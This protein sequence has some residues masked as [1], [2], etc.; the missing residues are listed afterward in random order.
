MENVMATGMNF[1]LFSKPCFLKGFLPFQALLLKVQ[2]FFVTNDAEFRILI[3]VLFGY[4]LLI[5]FIEFMEL[6]SELDF[7][8]L[9]GQVL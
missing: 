3:L 2:K 6:S 8:S 5:N 7:Q 9:G 4:H 1:K